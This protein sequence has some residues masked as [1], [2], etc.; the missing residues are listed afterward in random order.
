VSLLAVNGLRLVYDGARGSTVA[1]ED[2][3]LEVGEGEAVGLVGESGS[4]KSSLARALLGLLPRG[5]GRIT[6]GT[7]SIA[8]RD[9]TH[10]SRRDWETLRG[11]PMAMVFQDPLSSLNPVMRIGTQIG[12][13]VRR[14]DRGVDVAGRIEELLGLVKLPNAVAG[15]YPH[16]LSGGMRQRA[17]L[18]IALGCRPA[19]L[20]ADEPTTALDVTT[21]AEILA[22]LREL[23]RKL[24]MALLLISHDLGVVAD[25]CDRVVIMYAGRTVEWGA[26][27]DTFA[28]PGHPYASALLA[29]GRVMRNE[30]G[31]FVTVEGEVGTAGGLGC[32]FAPRC[33]R[34]M[35][36]C[37]T[38]MPPAYPAGGTGHAARCWLLDDQVPRGAP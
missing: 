14:H 24:G 32:P 16:E 13:S 20:V 15:A 34:V 27:A 23:R 5:V 3:T 9:V 37:Q 18:A 35:P 22:L 29:A 7:I 19:M 25:A 8:G 1:I 28:R 2:A 12:E 10:L 11:R 21:Q 30:Q 6:G 36:R 26:T 33:P 38:D 4:G 31:L 17:L